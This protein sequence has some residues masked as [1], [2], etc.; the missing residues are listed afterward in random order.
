MIKFYITLFI[1]AQLSCKTQGQPLK[2]K[3]EYISTSRRRFSM[4]FDTSVLTNL[5]PLEIESKQANRKN[6]NVRT[7][8]PKNYQ[9][10]TLFFRITVQ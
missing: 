4:K 6:I 7:Y 8:P 9:Y 3:F 1:L 10:I 5:Q 2:P